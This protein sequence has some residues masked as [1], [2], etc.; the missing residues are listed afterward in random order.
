MSSTRDVWNAFCPGP[1]RFAPPF[2]A[3]LRAGAIV[4]AVLEELGVDVD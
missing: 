4:A 2:F 3:R 1:D